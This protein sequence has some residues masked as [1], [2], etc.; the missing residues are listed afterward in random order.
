M[1]HWLAESFGK[2]RLLVALLVVTITAIAVWGNHFSHVGFGSKKRKTS[3]AAQFKNHIEQQFGSGASGILLVIESDTLFTPATMAAVRR[4]SSAVSELKSVAQVLDLDAVPVLDKFPVV[5]RLVP[6]ND[7]SQAAFTRARQRALSHPLVVGQ[8]LSPDGKTLLMPVVADVSSAA[9]D[10]KLGDVI[11]EITKAAVD[12][13]AESDLSVRL[14][15]ILPLHREQTEAFDSE[16]VRFQIIAY[17][18]VF[19]LAIVMFRGISA[20]LIV[21]GAPS[22]GLYWTLGFLRFLDQGINP[23]VQIILPVLVVMIG[24]T[25]GVHL[26]VDIRRSRAQGCEPLEASKDAIRHLAV[27]CALTTLT[28][29]I[30]FGSLAVASTEIIRDFGLDCMIGVGLVFVAVLTVIPLLSSTWMGRRVHT[31]HEH[32]II[33]KNLTFFEGFIDFIIRHARAI[34]AISVVAT[35]VMV[36]LGLTLRPDSTLENDF[37]RNSKAYAA[38]R[39]CDEAFGGVELI[40]VAVDWPERVT[41]NSGELKQTL[42]EVVAAIDDEPLV[43]HPLS[44]L[45][46]VDALPESAGDLGTVSLFAGSVAEARNFVRGVFRADLSRAVV[47]AR[48]RDYGSARYVSVFEGLESRFREIEQRHEGFR[49]RLTGDPVVRGRSLHEIIYDLSSSL[50]VAAGIILIV[51]GFAYR[52]LRIGLISVVPN[53][54]P[55]AVTASLLVLLGR[56]LEIT[57]VCAFTIC[58]GIA[59][60]DTIHFL[61]RFQYELAIDG[62]VGAAIRR[63]FIRVGTALILSS[64]VLVSGFATVLTSQMPGHQVFAGMACATIAAALVGDLIILPAILVCFTP[65]TTSVAAGSVSDREVPISSEAE[66]HQPATIVGKH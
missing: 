13:A 16:H 7:A 20:V 49:L 44:I 39:H 24:F 25:N 62:D 55:L 35:I 26:M 29:S 17:S 41:L 2:H 28:T 42:R 50:S 59:V 12:A 15:G 40:Q 63:S 64:V 36:G 61:S 51:M 22:L 19:L 5:E 31:G 60:D 45:N 46:V 6:E 66:T 21:A 65:S 56:P 14:T 57:S 32:D 53:L 58:L 38:L 1:T 10:V 47:I 23:L 4:V 33:N 30:G 43:R 8:L 11:D 48:I 54:F 27:A 3:E 34:T 52:S 9:I 18:I 37:P